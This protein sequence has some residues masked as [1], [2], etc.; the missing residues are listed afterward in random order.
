MVINKK[1]A[2]FGLDARIALAIFGALSVISGAALYSAIQQSKVISLV[3]E[4]NEITKALEQYMLDTGQDLGMVNSVMTKTNELL[5][6]NGVT[7]WNG[8]YYSAERDVL[9]DGRVNHSLYDWFVLDLAPNKD[10]SYSPT[11]GACSAAGNAGSV[12]NYWVVF[13]EVPND[14]SYAVDDYLDGTR[15][16][17]T[18]RVRYSNRT[19]G[20]QILYINTNVASFKQY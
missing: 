15:D 7:G 12:C 8:P 5:A 3:T 18:G 11:I 20:N 1:G 19:T 14:L 16:N 13:D 6:D 10:F 9:G 4:T 17:D 2:M